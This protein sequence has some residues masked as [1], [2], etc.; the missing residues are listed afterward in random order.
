MAI[1]NENRA[2]FVFEAEDA[3]L[4]GALRRF[5]KRLFVDELGWDLTVQGEEERDQFDTDQALHCALL[6]CDQIIGGFRLTPTT[7]PYLSRDV[8]PHLAS[9]RPFPARPDF[10]EVSRLGV[11]GEGS[12]RIERALKV[13][14]LMMHIA[15]YQRLTGLVAIADL[16]Y[17]RFLRRIGITTRRYGPPQAIGA[18]RFGRTLHA[19]AGEIPLADQPPRTLARLRSTLQTV[20][21]HDAPSLF[22][23][24]RLSA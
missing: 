17:E 1:S 18:D 11:I 21:I 24:Q 15:S 6:E 16:T 2:V 23:P 7:V 22:G 14:G 3:P 8:F 10:A 20:E 19:V 4:V 5:R 12:V 13:Y 9:S